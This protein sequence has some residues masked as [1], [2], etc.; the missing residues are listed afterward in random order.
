MTW[1]DT[2]GG[3]VWR[4]PIS[5]GTPQCVSHEHGYYQHPAWSPDGGTIAVMMDS[6][7]KGRPWWAEYHSGQLQ[8]ISLADGSVKILD[9]KVPSA[10]QFSFSA[11][12]QLVYYQQEGIKDP[13]TGVEAAFVSRQISGAKQEIAVL[14]KNP[15]A[16]WPVQLL[17]SPDKRYLVYQSVEDVCLVAVDTP[18]KAITLFNDQH[19]G[20]VIRFAH[21]V[22]PQWTDGGK[23]LNWT[24]GNKFYSIDP[25]KI[26]QAAQQEIARRKAAGIP[27]SL[28][29]TISPKPDREVDLG[30]K[31]ETKYAPGTIVLKNARI[32]TMNGDKVI[33]HGMM[34]IT[35]G[36]FTLIGD[37]NKVTVPADAKECDLKGKTIIPGFIDLHEHTHTFREVFPQQTWQYLVGLS[38][39]LTTMRDPSSN[40]ASFGYA[41]M[42]K[43]GQ[44]TGPRL[45][46]VGLTLGQGH[47]RFGNL[48]EAISAVIQR[49]AFDGIS[50]KQYAQDTRLQR[51]WVSI[52]CSEAGLNM[53]NEGNQTG[54]AYMLSQFGM[55]KD[56]SAGIEHNPA[57]GDVYRDVIQLYARSGTFLTPTLQVCYDRQEGKRYFDTLFWRQ[58]N[59]KLSRFTPVSLVKEINAGHPAAWSPQSINIINP[60]FL[61]WSKVDTRIV[62]AGGRIVLGSH[63][64]DQGIG[65]H[66]ELWALQMGGMTNMQ[67]LQCAT[68]RGAEALGVQQD[69][70]SIEVGKIAD[71]AILNSNP[72]DDIHNS[73]D[74]KY[75]MHNGILYDGDTLDEIWPEV[76]KCPDWRLHLTDTTNT[77]KQTN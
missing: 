63:G 24:Y 5:G 58:P 46:T 55:I 37:A 42:L 75:V 44:M 59:A 27:D 48:D 18:G 56:G 70:G 25:D 20:S 73:R 74:I 60:G 68:I 65:V 11:D 45:F 66:N 36:R 22:D 67:A 76:K 13:K 57:F 50:I 31:A 12:G 15:A 64:E 9:Q 34:V 21:G 41:E 16:P 62:R 33:E 77:N 54:Y 8:L 51:E 32:I 14:K 49:K 19:T 43:T 17:P 23:T 40:L 71:L 4:F 52:A 10:N 26:N 2:S 35:N 3:A 29:L 39:G 1:N 30:F 69:L 6:L 47:Y 7:P 72:L 38:Y 61:D 28:F 53:T